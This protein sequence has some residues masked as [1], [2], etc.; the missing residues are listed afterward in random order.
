MDVLDWDV[1]GRTGEEKCV[2]IDAFKLCCIGP[3]GVED[4]DGGSRCVD[5]T[6]GEGE[7]PRLSRTTPVK[8]LSAKVCENRWFSPDNV[9]DAKRFRRLEGSRSTGGQVMEDN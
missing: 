4:G 7:P 9:G 8:P 6:T 5:T 2:R 1:G 3:V